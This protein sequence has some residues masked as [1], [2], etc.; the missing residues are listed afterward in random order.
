MPF[1]QQSVIDPDVI[2]SAFKIV[3]FF[4][5]FLFVTD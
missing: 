5:L 1:L 3:D 4:F 2:E